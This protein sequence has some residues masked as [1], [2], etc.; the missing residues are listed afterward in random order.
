ML[1]GKPLPKAYPP[2]DERQER[3]YRALI[4]A[5]TEPPVLALPKPGLPYSID[6]DAC[7]HQVGC[8]LFQ[9]HSDYMRKPISFWSRTLNQAEKNYSP[10]EREG[11]AIVYAIKICRPYV[12]GA[13]F[14]IYSDYNALRWLM[15][16]KINCQGDC[17][18]RLDSDAHTVVEIDDEIP[19]FLME[20][21]EKDDQL[22]VETIFTIE[23]ILPDPLR[24][25]PARRNLAMALDCYTHVRNCEECARERIKL[26][27]YANPLRLFPPKGPLQD[28]AIDLLG[29][30]QKSARGYTHLLVITDRYTKLTKTVPLLARHLK[31]W[32]V[33]QAFINN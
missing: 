11:L 12:Q 28:V 14:T 30:L 24:G 7:K 15:E 1:K 8:A 21:E 25:P 32:D 33:A 22:I 5:V 13:H 31:A 17:M 6:T 20:H 10:S 29:P 27:R 23:Q 18:S 2:L 9:T 16:G 4:K 26:R 3:A 19:A